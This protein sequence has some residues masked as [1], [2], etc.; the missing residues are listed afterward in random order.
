MTR[1]D[2]ILFSAPMVT[3]IL[4]GRKDSMTRY[5]IEMQAYP[6]A[7]SPAA[8]MR[9]AAEALEAHAEGREYSGVEIRVECEETPRRGSW[10]R[11]TGSQSVNSG[12]RS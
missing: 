5:R 3:A 4:C 2:P 7:E 10:F 6:Y 12:G 9:K 11:S 1:S 8:A